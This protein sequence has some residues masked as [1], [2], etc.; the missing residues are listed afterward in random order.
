MWELPTCP[1]QHS[2]YMVHTQQR[3]PQF[4][5]VLLTANDSDLNF[6]QVAILEPNGNVISGAQEADQ[7]LSQN[8]QAA[9]RTLRLWKLNFIPHFWHHKQVRHNRKILHGD[10]D[11]G[12]IRDFLADH[13]RCILN[14]VRSFYKREVRSDDP[15]ECAEHFAYIDS[16]PL[17]F[18]SQFQL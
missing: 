14:N 6:K 5:G 4:R 8:L 17:S 1:P 13:L 3:L 10:K 11:A 18:N 2:T 7:S 15:A 16:L 12:Y 9:N